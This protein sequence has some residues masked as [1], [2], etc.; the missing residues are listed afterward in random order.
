MNVDYVGDYPNGKYW[1]NNAGFVRHGIVAKAKPGATA[2]AVAAKAQHT[3]IFGHI[4]RIEMVTRTIKERDQ[5]RMVHAFCPGCLSHIDGRVPGT[6]DQTN[7]QQ[8]IGLIEYNSNDILVIHSIPIQDGVALY[9]GRT[10]VGYDRT[11]ELREQTKWE[12]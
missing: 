4:H 2:V 5:N 10:F 6:T 3:E 12:F 1:L 9:N 11:K 8:G 7:W